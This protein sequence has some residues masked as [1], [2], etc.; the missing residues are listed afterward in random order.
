M[1]CTL[2]KVF[3]AVTAAVKLYMDSSIS[4]SEREQQDGGGIKVIAYKSCSE[5]SLLLQYKTYLQ[6]VPHLHGFHYR[7]S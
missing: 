7:G 2:C 6:G 4:F 5:L 3:P 1:Q